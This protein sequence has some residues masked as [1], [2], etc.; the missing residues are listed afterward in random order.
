MSLLHSGLRN[1]V[2]NKEQAMG[3]SVTRAIL[4]TML[5]LIVGAN[6]CRNIDNRL[7]R[8]QLIEF[9]K[10]V[11]DAQVQYYARFRRYGSF[12]ELAQEDLIS[13]DSGKL[14]EIGYVFYLE[15]KREQYF[16]RA[17]PIW[18]SE[19]S[20]YPSRERFTLYVDASGIIRASFD[21]MKPADSTSDP[22]S[23]K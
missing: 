9:T 21:P 15:N 22:I 23:P 20:Q 16:F 6:T 8:S 19:P 12:E 3:M 1:T 17:E 11:R 2:V 18:K 4:T 5:A 14:A 10:S 7:D 13:S